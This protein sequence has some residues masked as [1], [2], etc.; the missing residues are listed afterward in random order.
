MKT[1]GL[2]GGMSWE[3][4]VLY[5]QL[6]NEG[7]RERLGGLHSAKVLMHSVDF[8]EIEQFQ[9]NGQWQEAG[10][11]LGDA[12]LGLTL[13]GADMILI[14]T[15][16]MHK[17]APIIEAQIKVPLLHIADATGKAIK[18]QGLKKV[19]LLGAR[20]TMEEDFYRQ[21]LLDNFGLDVI[22]PEPEDREYVHQAI[23]KELCVGKFTDGTRKN[24]LTI[25]D[26]LRDQG[27]EGVILGCTEIP[28]LV[29]QDDTDLPLFNTAALH[30]RYALEQ[31]F[32][33]DENSNS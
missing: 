10:N 31:A 5:Y 1:I 19:G 23:F 15:N 27:A 2:L 24:Y 6:L 26:K 9:V 18:G 11:K 22:I 30:A 17:V 21:R 3:S 25:I 28:L 29:R 32:T 4:T 13:S 16:L 20:Y 33:E 14:C 8:A 7:V 12:A